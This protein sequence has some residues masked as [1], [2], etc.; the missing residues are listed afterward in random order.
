MNGNCILERVAETRSTNDDLMA[1]WRAGTLIDPIARLSKKQTHGKGRAGRTWYANAEDSLSFSL[2]FPFQKS[3]AALSGLSLVAGLAVIEGICSALNTSERILYQQ[4]LRLKWPNDIVIGHAKV[5]GILI[6]GGQTAPAEPSWMIIGVGL[7]V[8]SHIGDD[9]ELKAIR[10]GPVGALD[11]LLMHGQ[12][13]PDHDYIWLNLV[14]AFVR[15]C[16]DFDGRGFDPFIQRWSDWDA[17]QGEPVFTSVL[18]EKKIEGMA[19]GIDHTGAYQIQ[20][21]RALVAVHAGDLSLRRQ[22]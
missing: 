15:L 19:S 10:S 3:P 11:Q 17:Y 12:A 20:T 21:D 9:A 2:A 5:G 16:T 7:N 8:R 13:L 14:D 4:G 6:E 22:V 18:G 1:R